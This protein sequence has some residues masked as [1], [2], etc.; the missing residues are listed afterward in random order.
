MV[1]IRRMI[2]HRLVG[3]Y[4]A[5]I[6]AKWFRW[7]IETKFLPIIIGQTQDQIS[8]MSNKLNRAILT[9]ITNH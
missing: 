1:S 7:F 5:G 9:S 3:E 6:G 2:G 8:L 4:G